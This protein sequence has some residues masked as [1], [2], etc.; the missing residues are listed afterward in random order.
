MPQG[1]ACKPSWLQVR[2]S[3]NS[4]SVPNP[5]GSAMKAS[6]RSA[7]ERLALVHRVHDVKVGEALVSDLAGHQVLR[8]HA[9]RLPAC[10]ED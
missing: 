8:D 10:F 4:S 6:D 2:T 7:I 3:Q 1:F 5:P 9:D